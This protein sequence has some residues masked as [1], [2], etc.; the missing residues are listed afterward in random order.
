MI[1]I[2]LAS[3]WTLLVNIVGNLSLGRDLET[4]TWVA[5]EPGL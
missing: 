3:E 2:Y 1:F 4:K 5:E